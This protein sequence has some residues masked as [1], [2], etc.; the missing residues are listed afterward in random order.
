MYIK[1]GNVNEARRLVENYYLFSEQKFI[2][3]LE[4]NV[5]KSKGENKIND[6]VNLYDDTILHYAVFHNKEKLVDF[7]LKNNADPFKLNKVSRYIYNKIQRKK[8]LLFSKE[9]GSSQ[10]TR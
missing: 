3:F 4:A 7:L 1:Q 2:S 9:K 10:H 5:L 6:P 8:S